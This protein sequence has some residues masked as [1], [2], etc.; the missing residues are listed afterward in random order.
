MTAITCKTV[1]LLEGDLTQYETE[2]AA[3]TAAFKQ[4][5][6]RY[7]IDHDNVDPY[8]RDIPGVVDA[9]LEAYLIVKRD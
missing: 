7:L 8:S 5:L 3:K 9:L 1:W 2:E 6:V 4:E